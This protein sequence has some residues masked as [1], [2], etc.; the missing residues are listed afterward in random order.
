M[1]VENGE[2]IMYG[3]DWDD[4]E[5]I[6]TVDEAIAY[7]N[8]IGFLP[9]FKNDIPGFSLE[10]R[11]APEGWWSDDPERDPWMWLGGDRRDAENIAYGKFF[12][13]KAGFISGKNGFRY[14]QTT[15][16]RL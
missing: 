14:S 16:G 13:K 5:C 12:D 8:E 10:E 6:H 15:A 1:A 11:T 4:P 9:L 2:W 3:V 7:I